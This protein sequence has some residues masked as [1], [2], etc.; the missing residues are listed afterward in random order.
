VGDGRPTDTEREL[1]HRERRAFSLLRRGRLAAALA[2]AEAEAGSEVGVPSPRLALLAAEVRLSLGFGDIDELDELED[3]VAASGDRALALRLEA[4]LAELHA[5]R[6]DPVCET[7][8]ARAL[9][10]I[11]DER[12]TAPDELWARG[13]LRRTLALAAVLLG[14]DRPT[15]VDE[16]MEQAKAD[17]RRGGFDAERARAA[18]ELRFAWVLAFGEDV[19]RA[20]DTVTE[21]LAWLRQ[22]GADH[23]DLLLGY[24]IALDLARGDFPAA[25]SGRIE[26]DRLAATADRPLHPVAR[27]LSGFVELATRLLASGPVPDVLAAAEDHLALVRSEVFTGL[28]SQF[29]ALAGVMVDAGHTRPEDLRLARRWAARAAAGAPHLPKV[30][31]ELASLLTRLDLLERGDRAAVE[32]VDADLEAGRRLDLGRDAAQRALRAALAAHRAGRHDVA[33]RLHRAA[34]ADLPPP[35]D[36]L[37]WE[38]ALVAQVEAARATA[39]T[40]PV[41][42]LLLGPTVRAEVGGTAR[43][44][45][46]ALARLAVALVAEGGTAPADR[47][48]DAVWPDAPPDAGRARLR[49]ALHRLRSALRPTG[50][51]PAVR[52]DP[53]PG[54]PVLRR[55]G[56]V[57]L[58]SHVEVDVAVFERLASG[59]AEDRRAG[60]DLYAGDVAQVQLAYHDIAAPLR[61]RLAA[62][63][64]H[65]ADEALD[66]PQLARAR[67]VRIATVA[68]SGAGDDPALADLLARAERRLPP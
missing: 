44:L 19:Q 32:A 58:A 49:V 8:A 24:R 37:V 66:D 30:Q 5:S 47:L 22:M 14:P 56:T 55:G 48:I 10:G 7:I 18:A 25:A 46:A 11:A 12:L 27:A 54:D 43:P 68:A 26:L 28:A 53:V 17:F 35:A 34:V 2:E 6:G 13:R 38:T 63:W 9:A 45:S 15:G 29:V 40:A 64:R 20:A 52:D 4:A 60:L 33:E 65:I 61:R 67:I 50:D 3:A 62:T 59:S 21:C 31:R 1:E 42:L 57:A 16:L 51:D 23:V 41:R 36:R 39:A